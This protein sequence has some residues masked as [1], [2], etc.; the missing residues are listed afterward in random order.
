MLIKESTKLLNKKIKIKETSSNMPSVRKMSL[1]KTKK[2]LMFNANISY[3]QGVRE[4]INFF[5]NDK[6]SS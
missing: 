6:Q 1:S 2:K 5:K 4:I 3:K